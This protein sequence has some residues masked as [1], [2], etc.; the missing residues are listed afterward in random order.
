MRLEEV[1]CSFLSLDV[2]VCAGPE[3]VG[4]CQCLGEVEAEVF[5]AVKSEFSDAVRQSPSI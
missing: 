2:A 5:Y 3:E 4:D 1:R